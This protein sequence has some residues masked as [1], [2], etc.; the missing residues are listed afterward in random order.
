MSVHDSWF[1]WIMVVSWRSNCWENPNLD[2]VRVGVCHPTSW[3]ILSTFEFTLWT[4]IS[5]A[6]LKTPEIL[7]II[8]VLRFKIHISW[9]GCG[10]NLCI[11][12]KTVGQLDIMSTPGSTHSAGTIAWNTCSYSHHVGMVPWQQGWARISV[13]T[14]GLLPTP[15]PAINSSPI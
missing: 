1:Q 9:P 14:L 4:F 12:S 8:I 7:P 3:R 2:L 10:F 15:Q 5:P 11:S 13:F 6:L